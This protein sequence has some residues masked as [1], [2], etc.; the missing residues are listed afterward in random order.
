MADAKKT[1]VTE[2][3]L[4][5]LQDEYNTLVH[6]TREEVKAE[7]KEARSLGDLS[8]NADYDAAR[9]KQAQVENRIAEL[10]EMLKNYEI[11]STKGNSKTVRIGSTV[12]LQFQ[13]TKEEAVYSIVGRTE[14]DPLNGKISNETA[15]AQAILDKRVGQTVEVNCK[16][17]Y[18]VTII[19]VK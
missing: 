5:D 9:D 10:E 3:G 16:K 8:E 15:L 4:K 12:Q 1:Y 14:A 11:I 18:E 6:V 17:P 19:S 7:L 2:Q 13:D